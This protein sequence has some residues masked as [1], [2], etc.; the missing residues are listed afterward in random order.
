MDYEIKY[1]PAY[2]PLIWRGW[3]DFGCGELG[4]WAC[5]TLDGPFWALDLDAPSRVSVLNLEPIHEGFVPRST[6]MKFEFPARGNKPPVA[7]HWY[8]GGQH[9]APPLDWDRRVP[10]PK[11]G[12]LMIG[13]KHTLMT[14]A[15]PNSPR[16]LLPDDLW[17]DFKKNRPPKTIPRVLDGPFQEWIRAIKGEGPPPGS[18]FEYSAR[19]TEMSLVGVMAQRSGRDIEWDAAKMRVSNH[20]DFEHI[21]RQPARRGWDFGAGVWRG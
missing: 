13:D 1:S 4:D 7:L 17:Q 16:L 21:V 10:F 8:D 2:A 14:G 3:W 19:L 15:R 18:S 12:M 6:H 20:R 11:S 5:H 9:P